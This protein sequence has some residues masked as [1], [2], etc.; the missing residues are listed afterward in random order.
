MT[1]AVDTFLLMSKVTCSLGQV[2]FQS[3]CK[4]KCLRNI[5][6]CS[7]VKN[8]EH[9]VVI[10]W[11]GNFGLRR[12]QLEADPRPEWDSQVNNRNKI[13]MILGVHKMK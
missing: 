2:K 5:A 11:K 9:V 10:Y 6:A 3:C 1:T 12:P 4:V 13:A 8:R 7:P